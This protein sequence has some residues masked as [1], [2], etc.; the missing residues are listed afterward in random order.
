MRRKILM[1]VLALALPAGTVLATQAVAS[2][3]GAPG[4]PISCTGF[5]GTVT[6]GAPLTTAGVATSSKTA[7]ATTVSGTGGN[8]SGHGLTVP[9]GLNIAGGKNNK[10][11]KTD[12]RYNKTAG[13]KYVTGEWSEFAASGGTLAKSVKTI[14]F[15]IGGTPVSFKAKSASEVI[16]G[17]CGSAVGFQING[18]VKSGTYNT[19]SATI[20]ACLTGDGGGSASGNFGAD[21]NTAQGVT[22]ATIGGNSNATL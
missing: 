6:F 17:A 13:I 21:Y 22:F 9:G 14:N 18:Q 19:K 1:G 4:T 15:S 3:K 2:A 7:G 16:G 8:C 12:P 11:A 5:S 10:L 20:L